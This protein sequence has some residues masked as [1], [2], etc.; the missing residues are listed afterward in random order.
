MKNITEFNEFK[1]INEEA[2][3]DPR[4]GSYGSGG[5]TYFAN[6][7]GNFAG[8]ENTLVGSAVIKLFAFVK[9]K[10]Y[11]VMLYTWFK[12]NLYREYMSGLMRYIIRNSM[13]LPTAK[14]EYIATY[15]NKDESGEIIETV[16]NVKIKITPIK[17]GET[18][19]VFKIGAEVKNEKDEVVKDGYYDINEKGLII[20]VEGG[21]ISEVETKMID[22]EETP[23]VSGSTE[24][25]VSGT[26][27]TVEIAEAQPLM[28]KDVAEYIKLITT[29][30]NKSKRIRSE[31]A[32][33]LI[34]EID[35]AVSFFKE[36]VAEMNI[37]L[38]DA[39]IENDVIIRIK[40]DM[41]MYN[42]NIK[43]LNELKSKINE[44][45]TSST[46]AQTETKP[47]EAPVPAIVGENYNFGQ[48]LYEEVDI[49]GAG[50]AVK[51]VARTAGQ[52]K[53]GD[54]KVTKNK[55]IG[56][57]LNML[58]QVDIDLNDPEFTKQFDSPEIK[59]ACTEVVLEGKSEICK[60][61]LGAERLYVKG[62]NTI[63]RKLQNNWLKMVQTVKNQF[64]KF[65][66]VDAI[67]PIVLRNKLSSNEV[68]SFQNDKSSSTIQTPIDLMNSKKASDN[69]NLSKTLKIEGAR[70]N[71]MR[72]GD[73]GI[74]NLN[75]EQV[76]F[77]LNKIEHPKGKDKF[78]YTYRIVSSVS[79]GITEVK[80]VDELPKM[81]NSKLPAIF[82]PEK[83]EV[84]LGGSKYTYIATFILGNTTHLSIGHST[85]HVNI[86][87]L[88]SK[89]KINELTKDN[90][91]DCVFFYKDNTNKDK[92]FSSSVSD[93]IATKSRKESD[94]IL[95]SGI[96][97]IITPAGV[98]KFGIDENIKKLN[99][100]QLSGQ[101]NNLNQLRKKE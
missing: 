46:S 24:T 76:L 66:L 98:S 13:N 45:L 5:E 83:S 25:E 8:A 23:T 15:Y 11:Q 36:S 61:Q 100:Q 69:I 30:L 12:P 77:C 47:V 59:K 101:Y 70:Y 67:D 6:V 89:N 51:N 48:L 31:D 17:E 2:T 90:I 26:T 1:R 38:S 40:Q 87:L 99:I 64:S 22:T 88:Y 80:S 60:I 18:Y 82:S 97:W 96:P 4:A 74:T 9:R 14:S 21:K 65:M 29:E 52:I 56:D 57:E 86:I 37:E 10:G 19:S 3:A 32:K 33:Q 94:I 55:R 81:L 42:N 39:K 50:G 78:L 49:T 63:D 20:K 75:G 27:E 95:I 85:N 54:V 34:N 92:G 91:K 53:V 58:S 72:E 84:I 44:K 7:K 41:N 71:D 43:Y 73:F 93:D 28:D 62:D 16:E 35:E 68:S 79:S